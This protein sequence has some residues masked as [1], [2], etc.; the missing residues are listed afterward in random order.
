[1]T[2][3]LPLGWTSAPLSDLVEVLDG[4]RRPVNAKERARRQGTVPYFG[5]AGQVG[6]IDK[7]IFDE[8]LLLLGEDGVQFFDP[9]RT[10]AFLVDGPAWVNNHAHVLRVDD[11]VVDRTYLKYFLDQFDYRGY[12][13]GTTRLKLTQGAMRSIPV[14]VPPRAEQKRIARAMDEQMSLIDGAVRQGAALRSRL[15]LLSACLLNQVVRD[16][17]AAVNRNIALGELAVIRGGIQKQ[18][19]RHPEHPT[20]GYPFLRVANVGRRSLDLA[21]IHRIRLDE[22]EVATA[23]LQAGDL[24]VVEGNGSPDHIGRAAL[25]SGEIPNTTHQNHLIRVRA[26]EALMPEYLELVW[27]APSTSAQIRQVASTTS[28]LYTLSTK[29]VASITVPV[30]SLELQKGLVQRAQQELGLAERAA[31]DARR[32]GELVESLRRSVLAAATTGRL[33]PQD[34]SDEP[35]AAVLQRIRTSREAAGPTDTGARHG[36]VRRT[37]TTMKQENTA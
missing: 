12:A 9:S 2:R 31:V 35:A 23:I 19:R 37:R 27:N 33:S 22:G 26:T 11:E 28:G 7:P 13:N 36:T 1:M 24:L 29:K 21:D 6:W 15:S 17:S 4:Q 32:V 25:W 18:P 30:P 16:A 3:D 8:P 14:V 5:A 34:P 10:K 20:D